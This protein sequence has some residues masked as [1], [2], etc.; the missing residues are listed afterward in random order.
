MKRS[1]PTPSQPP[2]PKARGG[3]GAFSEILVFP[4]AFQFLKGEYCFIFPQICTPSP[5]LTLPS[6][7]PFSWWLFSFFLTVFLSFSSLCSSCFTIW[8]CSP[9]QPRSLYCNL[10]FSPAH[11]F[12]LFVSPLPLPSLLSCP[13]SPMGFKAKHSRG[14][15]SPPAAA[16]WAFR[17]S[18]PIQPADPQVA[19]LG[20]QPLQPENCP[21]G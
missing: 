6:L 5:A 12:P 7:P 17:S 16:H 14:W 11:A 21:S 18:V 3:N 13:I 10:S 8:F 1:L 19:Q 2:H 9:Y 15:R 4:F 20:N